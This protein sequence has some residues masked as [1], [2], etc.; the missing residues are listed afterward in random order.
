[1]KNLLKYVCI[2]IFIMLSLTFIACSNNTS[3]TDTHITTSGT[4]TPSST[5]T[6][7][8]TDIPNKT[9]PAT[10]S[11]DT[12]PYVFPD[13]GAI[14][15][16][17][18]SYS[19]QRVYESIDE[20]TYYNGVIFAPKDWGGATPTGPIAYWYIVTFADGTKEYLE[21]IGFGFEGQVN[22]SFTK[23]DNPRAGVILASH[24]VEGSLRY[25]TYLLVSE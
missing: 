2:L 21:Y 14:W 9:L 20:P 6:F 17:G 24:E 23:H 3:N 12:V 7:N 18:K 16:D 8:T 10:P 13:H 19:F 11:N 15:Y 22:V 5:P 25:V 4:L 1:M